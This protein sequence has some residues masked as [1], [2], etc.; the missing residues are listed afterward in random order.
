[1]FQIIERYAPDLFVKDDSGHTPAV[2][3]GDN[4][5][6]CLRDYIEE[7]EAMVIARVTTSPNHLIHVYAS[8][9]KRHVLILCSFFDMSTRTARFP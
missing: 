3:A 7:Q 5:H 6:F 9:K 8:M 1:M 2:L 4:G